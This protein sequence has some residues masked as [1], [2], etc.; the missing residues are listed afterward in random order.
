MAIKQ[1]LGIAWELTRDTFNDWIDD[2]VPRLGAA[3][4]YYTLF[5]LA[6]MLVVA[7][8]VAGLVFGEEAARGEMFGQ[9]QALLGAE[10]AKLVESLLQSVSKPSHGIIATVIGL[11]TFMLGATT[12]FVELQSSLNTVWEVQ[13]KPGRGVKGLL[14][15]RI[16]SFGM[17]L[18][19]GFLL[20]TSLVVSAGLSAFSTFMGDRVPGFYYF[21]QLLNLVLSLAVQ[22]VLFAMMYKLLPDVK[23]AWRDVWVGSFVTSVLFTLG[24]FLLGF[25][26]GSSSVTSGYGAAG[27]VA[28]L[29]LWVYYSTQILL[30]GA[31]FTQI[32]AERFGGHIEPNENAEFTPEHF[33]RVKRQAAAKGDDEPR[34]SKP[35][36]DGEEK[37]FRITPLPGSHRPHHA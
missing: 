9:L 13:P 22:T 7:I 34:T 15:D 14:H 18:G 10:G 12:A 24:K 29:L 16:L 11:V 21:A 31:E 6:P 19:I 2:N 36:K 33:A 23:V 35:P 25:Y 3:L 5:S 1:K 26:I 20:L 17:L 37:R 32:W 30:L 28:V 27:S 8:G 4:A